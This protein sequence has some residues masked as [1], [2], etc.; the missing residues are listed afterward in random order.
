MLLLSF[1]A[2]AQVERFLSR[3][4]TWRSSGL[5]SINIGQTSFANWANGGENQLNI[6]TLLHYRLQFSSGKAT[7]ENNIDAKYG[8][9]IF[10]D[11]KMKKTNDKIDYASKFGHKASKKWNYSYYLSYTSQFARGYKYPNDSTVVSDFMAPGYFMAGAGMD[12]HPIKELSIMITPITYKL[13]IVNNT[14]LAND[15][16]FGVKKAIVDANGNVIVPGE[17][18]RSETGAFVKVYYQKEFKNGFSVSSKL[19]LFSA[20]NNK[21]ENVDLTWATFVTYRISKFFIAT[22]S[23]DLLYDDDAII[24]IDVN[25][26]GIKEVVGPRLQSKQSFGI[27]VSLNL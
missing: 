8:T 4:S 18:F 23:L 2:N 6:N 5:L 9:L 17:H 13:T 10:A 12:Y 11:M 1:V 26:D 25:N 24:K 3:D 20:F 19:E 16:G 14:L 27:G 15:G 7:W 22:F 21:P